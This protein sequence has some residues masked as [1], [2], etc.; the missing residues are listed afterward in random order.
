MANAAGPH[1]FYLRRKRKNTHR[2][3]NTPL[4]QHDT[5]RCVS[6]SGLIACAAKSIKCATAAAERKTGG[7]FSFFFFYSLLRH[8]YD[9][10][11]GPR[12]P[13]TD[14]AFVVFFVFFLL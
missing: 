10:V 6:G 9:D 12:V 11:S 13:I 3:R 1:L 2:P 14:V 8:H 5:K 4:T 7:L